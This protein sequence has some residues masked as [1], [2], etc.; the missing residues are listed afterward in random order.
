MRERF[1]TLESLAVEIGH[2]PTWVARRLN[3]LNLSEL[4][5]KAMEEKIF[6]YMT[7]SHY[8]TIATFPPE[9]QDNIFD[10]IR[11][12][13]GRDLKTASVKK[14]SETL[15][16]N[17]ATLLSSRPWQEEGCGGCPACKERKTA[18][19]LFANL[20]PEPRCMNREYLERKRKEYVATLAAEKPEAVLV[21]HKY[22]VKDEENPQEDDPLSE[23]EILGPGDWRETENAEEGTPAIIADGPRAGTQITIQR[24]KNSGNTEPKKVKTLA[25]RKE[26][27]SRQR[28]RKAIEMMIQAIKDGETSTPDRH[29]I[30]L[31]AACK[32]TR[33]VCG[34]HFDY[35]TKHSSNVM[36]LPDK[37]MSCASLQNKDASEREKIDLF[38]WESICENIFTELGTGQSGQD[39][40]KWAEAGVIASLVNYDLEKALIDA[41]AALPDPKSW[42]A[43]AKSEKAQQEA[44]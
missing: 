31:M 4:W 25:E 10:Y 16:E 3:L 30:Y 20:I 17:F 40:P 22:Q 36:G 1:T 28:K 21:S 18:G 11:G 35:K 32:G 24:P 13:E 37:I 44:A 29:I 42:E 39:E 41:T 34:D 2:S 33:A 14:F 6:G 19:Y 15:Y 7:V 12:V 27:K 26:A 38:F 9:I 43:L 5:K 8:E 23:N